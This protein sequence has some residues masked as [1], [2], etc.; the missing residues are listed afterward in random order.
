[1]VH[2]E[3]VEE[4]RQV[5]LPVPTQA[6]EYSGMEGGVRWRGSRAS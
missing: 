5:W 6:P 1:M 3:L 4:A 2:T